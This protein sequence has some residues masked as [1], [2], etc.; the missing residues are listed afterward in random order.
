MQSPQQPETSAKIEV[1]LGSIYTTNVNFGLLRAGDKH[2][3]LGPPTPGGYGVTA[4]PWLQQTLQV[5]AFGLSGGKAIRGWL[6]EQGIIVCRLR[7]LP[8]GGV[9]AIVEMPGGHRAILRVVRPDF[10]PPADEEAEA[11]KLGTGRPL[12][13]GGSFPKEH[14]RLYL[15]IAMAQGRAVFY[16]AARSADLKHAGLAGAH[17]QIALEEFGNPQA[18]DRLAQARYIAGKCLAACA[19]A[20]IVVTMAADGSYSL[21]RGQ[22][23]G[24][25]TPALPLPADAVLRTTGCGDAHHSGWISE[26]LLT[27]DLPIHERQ[28]RAA[29]MGSV[30]A[31]YHAAGGRPTGMDA[32]ELFE[33]PYAPARW[34]A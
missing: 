13:L 23:E 7:M 33:R 28:R 3:P 21:L 29:R 25:F 16:N 26:W 27:A 2:D 19:A 30:V 31:A 14:E 22:T 8:A 10:P 12:I 1:D 6:A 11:L 32:L 24:L 5:H 4:A 9:N 20:G 34:A 18:G 15:D 17:L